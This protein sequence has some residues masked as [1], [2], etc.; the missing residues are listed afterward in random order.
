MILAALFFLPLSSHG[1]TRSFVPTAVPRMT[2]PATVVR[3]APA[4]S[5]SLSSVLP[6]AAGVSWASPSAEI[7]GPSIPSLPLS[8]VPVLETV[9][10]EVP[11]LPARVSPPLLKTA[12]ARDATAKETL[13][14]TA[15]EFSKAEGEGMG[16]KTAS[17]KVFD[18]VVETPAPPVQAV[19]D[20]LVHVQG[21]PDF[22]SVADVP[23]RLWVAEVLEKA[24]R[25]RT[26]R[27]VLRR[28]AAVASR[29][30]LPIPVQIEDLR[31]ENGSFVYDWDVLQLARSLVRQDSDEAAPILVHELLH[32]V[33]RDIGLPVDALE[34][35]LEAHIVTLQVFREL[36]LRPDNTTF[37]RQFENALLRGGPQGAITWLNGQYK[38]NIGILGGGSVRGYVSKLKE[39]RTRVLRRI[40]A[41]ERLLAKHADMLEM[42][43][44]AGFPEAA[45]QSYEADQVASARVR[46]AEIKKQLGWAD[47]DLGILATP[48]G[49][50]AYRA[51]SQRVAK[52]I[53]RFYDTLTR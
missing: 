36:G 13:E 46:L 48:Q 40:K 7:L 37:S 18:G 17:D 23:D 4:V 5:F 43:R 21:L 49:A 9:L 3:A 2:L 52:R 20:R 45:L 25:T 35:E 34:M 31:T 51:F 38:E 24:M 28:A 29:R 32:F 14:V 33:Q 6:S 30:G 44:D 47:R 8:V 41:A 22:L 15:D 19:D 50:E 39:R 12:P 16:E 26:G 11:Q 10:R 53:E 1:Q 42:M 27:Q